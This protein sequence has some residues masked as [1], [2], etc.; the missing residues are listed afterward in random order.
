MRYMFLAYQCRLETDDRTFGDLFYACCDELKDI[1]FIE[2]LYRIL[3]LAVEGIRKMGSY[4]EKTAQSF[5][6][7]I[8]KAALVYVNLSKNKIITNEI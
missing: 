1:S 8:M 5:F 7:M 4:C 2:A 6:D 3:S